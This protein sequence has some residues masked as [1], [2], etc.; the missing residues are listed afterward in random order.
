MKVQRLFLVAIF[1]LSYTQLVKGQTLPGCPE[2]CGNVTLEYPFGFSPDCWRAEDPSF[3]LNCVNEKL[4]YDGLEVVNIS[5]SSQIRVLFPAS[6]VCYDSKG[7]FANGTYYYSDLGNLTLSDNNTV[8]AIGC[9]SYAFV[10]SNGT[11][12]NSVG[13]ISACD[14]P[15][16]ANGE[17]NGE[18]CCQNPVPAGNN[19]FIVRSYRFDN[20][21][22]VKPVFGSHCIYAFLVENGKFKYNASKNYSYLQNRTAGLP[23]VLD[24]SIKGETCRQAG[25]KKCGVNGTCSNIASGIGYICKCR[26][27]YHGNPYLQNGCQGTQLCFLFITSINCFPHTYITC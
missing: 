6:Y 7:D 15:S 22:S 8:T 26:G 9:N 21:T 19:W 10:S 14:A 23:V 4:F 3:K 18:G 27:G 11:R 17:C 12:R 24:W 2:K 20:D 1:C 13:C 5:H 25:E 16:V